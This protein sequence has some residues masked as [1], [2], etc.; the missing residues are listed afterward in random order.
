MVVL[1]AVVPEEGAGS[2][3]PGLLALYASRALASMLV[4]FHL[5][6]HHKWLKLKKT[7]LMIFPSGKASSIE[8][9]GSGKLCWLRQISECSVSGNQDLAAQGFPHPQQLWCQGPTQAAESM[10]GIFPN[11][12]YYSSCYVAISYIFCSLNNF[13][14]FVL[15]IFLG[16]ACTNWTCGV[17][18]FKGEFVHSWNWVVCMQW[19]RVRESLSHQQ[20]QLCGTI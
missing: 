16:Y 9:R 19:R 20:L 1:H 18:G 5:A 6:P 14:Y 7:F 10:F 8:W 4:S 15:K 13:F 2:H 17:A 3:V 11:C 12:S